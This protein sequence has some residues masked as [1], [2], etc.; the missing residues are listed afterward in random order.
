MNLYSVDRQSRRGVLESVLNTKQSC[1]WFDVIN[2][3]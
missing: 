3:E 2:G 1:E